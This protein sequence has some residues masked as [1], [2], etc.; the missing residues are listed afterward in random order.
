MDERWWNQC[1]SSGDSRRS[2]CHGWSRT[3]SGAHHFWNCHVNCQHSSFFLLK[4][5]IFT[6]NQCF[7]ITILLQLNC[8]GFTPQR[9][10][11][12]C[13][14]SVCLSVTF[15]RPVQ[16]VEL[17]G[18]IFAPPN[19]QGPWAVYI[20]ILGKNWKEFY[21]IVQVKYKEGMNNWRFSTNISLYFENG[22]RN[23]HSYNGRRIG[24]RMRSIKWCHFQWPWVITN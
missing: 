17:F 10:P 19:S 6:A 20:K 9:E 5:L 15:V 3:R 23:G 24:T 7:F 4:K 8:L 22:T 12:V 1:A 21:G 16:R 11:P 2:N 18:I 14:L 13:R